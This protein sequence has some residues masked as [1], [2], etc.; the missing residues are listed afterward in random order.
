AIHPDRYQVGEDVVNAAR[1]AF[2]DQLDAVVRP[3]GLGKWTFDLWRANTLQL[4]AAGVPESQVHVTGLGTG[5]STP[6]F[7]HRAENPCGRFVA[8]ARL[9]GKD[10]P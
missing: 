4:V 1:V 7:S 5:P 8:A 3:D 6:F 2:G 9:R 10:L